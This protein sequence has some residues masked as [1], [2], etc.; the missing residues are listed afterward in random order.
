MRNRNIQEGENTAK[1]KNDY[2]SRPLREPPIVHCFICGKD[3]GDDGLYR[4]YLKKVEGRKSLMA[5]HPVTPFLCQ[6]CAGDRARHGPDAC[7]VWE[8]AKCVISEKEEIL[9]TNTTLH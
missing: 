8:G 3:T 4:H 7:V 9:A 6:G 2:T 5:P 1:S